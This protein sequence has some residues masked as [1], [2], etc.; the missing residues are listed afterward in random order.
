MTGENKV[1]AILFIVA[2]IAIITGIV[3]QYNITV[4]RIEA[5]TKSN[6]RMDIQG[7][8]NPRRD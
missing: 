1:V 7:N 8:C 2:G 4:A 6:G 5:C 3:A